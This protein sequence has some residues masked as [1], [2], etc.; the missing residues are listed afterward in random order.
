[1]VTLTDPQG[2]VLSWGSAG[3]SGFKGSR[4]SSPYAAQVAAEGAARKAMEQ[5][6]RQIEVFVKGPGSGREA[7]IR[8]LQTSGSDRHIHH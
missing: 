3:S 1:M 7:A 6:L 2:G 5:G 8:A 4:K